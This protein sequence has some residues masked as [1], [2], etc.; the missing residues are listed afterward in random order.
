MK[1]QGNLSSTLLNLCTTAERYLSTNT[2]GHPGLLKTSLAIQQALSFPYSPTTPRY[3]LLS[4]NA[5]LN[6]FPQRTVSERSMMLFT[7]MLFPKPM[8]LVFYEEIF[9]GAVG[10]ECYRSSA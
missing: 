7:S 1:V 3:E 9:I 6:L 8:M 2:H 5:P 4:L 10:R